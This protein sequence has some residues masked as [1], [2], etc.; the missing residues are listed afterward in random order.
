MARIKE[1]LRSATEHYMM[2]SD[3]L[4]VNAISEHDAE[5]ISAFVDIMIKMGADNNLQKLLESYKVIKD[6]DFINLIN[7][8]NESFEG[9]VQEK[10]AMINIKDQFVGSVQAIFSFTRAE[11]YDSKKNKIF[12]VL[13]INKSENLKVP[14]A[15]TQIIFSDEEELEKEFNN[16]KERLSNYSNLIF[17]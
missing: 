9:S 11:Y 6:S 16:L 15:N 1:N 13:I 5:I 7:S 4:D 10:T 17:V 14:Y 12:P 3:A 8:Y 2:F